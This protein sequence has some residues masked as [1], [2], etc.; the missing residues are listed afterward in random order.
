MKQ[1][2]IQVW[3]CLQNAQF[4]RLLKTIQAFRSSTGNITVQHFTS[5]YLI[6]TTEPLGHFLLPDECKSKI[7]AKLKMNKRYQEEETQ[8]KFWL[9]IEIRT[10][11]HFACALFFDRR[12]RKKCWLLH[13]LDFFFDKK[14]LSSLRTHPLLS[15]IFQFINLKRKMLPTYSFIHQKFLWA[16]NRWN[17]ELLVNYGLERLFAVPGFPSNIHLSNFRLLD[18]PT[19]HRGFIE[20]LFCCTEFSSEAKTMVLKKYLLHLVFTVVRQIELSTGKYGRIIESLL[21]F[22]LKNEK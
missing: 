18:P 11:E 12:F 4:M 5:M 2:S 1:K 7:S 3:N 21:I 13:W 16:E 17:T 15:K 22:F 8:K 9:W 19:S 14:T 10:L 6:Q 20:L